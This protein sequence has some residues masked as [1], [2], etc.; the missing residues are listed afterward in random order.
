MQNVGSNP[1]IRVVCVDDSKLMLS[2]VSN[3]L[4][5]A[6]DMQVVGAAR[7]SQEARAMIRETNPD[8]VTLDVEMPGMNGLEFLRRI[9]ELRPMPVIMVSTLTAAGTDVTL[10]ALELG[11]VDAIAKPAGQ[12]AIRSFGET[13][14][15]KVRA[16]ARARVR[17]CAPLQRPAQTTIPPAGQPGPSQSAVSFQGWA[18]NLLAIGASTGGVSAISLLLAA[19]PRQFPPVVITQHMPP[20][21]TTRLAAR[22]DSVL[23]H[24]VAE[25]R[26]GEA[27]APGNIRIAPGIQHLKIERRGN[28]LVT[29]LDPSAPVSGHRPSVDVMF[30]SVAAAAG[31]RAVGVILTGMGRDGADGMLAMRRAGAHCIGQSE[32]SCVVYGMPRAA[33]ELG[34]VHEEQD[35]EALPARI[36]A[37]LRMPAIRQA[38]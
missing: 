25:A 22:L 21:F 27:L 2:I 20:E 24:T 10:N 31:P 16:A 33:R 19:L 12:D 26:D 29:R 7:S 8:V 30:S 3:A 23:P 13:L 37:A 5:G 14:R 15:A 11:A 6:A 35:I 4:S 28:E 9:M 18:R 17:R 32:Q 36:V 1:T 38:I 34:A